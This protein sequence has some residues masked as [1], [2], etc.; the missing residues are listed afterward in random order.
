MNVD[1]LPSTFSNN[2]MLDNFLCM[3]DEEYFPA[4]PSV[5]INNLKAI[6]SGDKKVSWHK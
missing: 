4:Y 1:Y 6:I 5:I 2:S 3:N